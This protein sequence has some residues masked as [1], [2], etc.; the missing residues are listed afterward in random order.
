MIPIEEP[1]KNKTFPF[2]S[3]GFRPFFFAAGSSS[4]LLMLIWFFMYSL[5]MPL[6]QQTIA[7]QI[8][9]AHEMIFAYTMAVIVG[10][11]LTAVKNWTNIQTLH[12]KPLMLL[13]SLWLIARFLPFFSV[14]LILQAFIDSTFL[15]F[16]FLALATPIIKAKSWN[17]IGILSKV[18]LMALAHIVFYLGLLGILE[19]GVMWGLY[20]AFYLILALVFVMARRV[21]PFFIERSLGLNQPLNN[22]LWLD[23]SSLVLFIGYVIFDIYWP[24]DLVFAFAFILFCLHTLRLYHWHHKGLWSFPL[25]WS[26]YLAYSILVIAFGIKSLS[27]IT[28]V[29]AFLS[30]HAFA[31]GIGLITLSMMSR[32]T[33][34]HTGRDINQYPPALKIALFLILAGFIVRVIF[35]LFNTSFY[36][37]W[38]IS[39]QVLWC[40]AFFIFIWVYTPMFFKKRV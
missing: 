36:S 31:F 5:N 12:G 22:P 20:G 21:V 27:Y 8:W 1:H 9:H 4:V 3:L 28:T 26:L 24:S 10:F 19:H 11:L 15:L 6:L 14:P 23:R 38:I 17:N 25:L 32:V 40:G 2:S 33:L 39:A 13:L 18:L 30:I 37:L 35:P 16:A 29:S 7:P 34:G